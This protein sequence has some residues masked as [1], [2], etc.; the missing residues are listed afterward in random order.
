[1]ER[2]GDPRA[3]GQGRRQGRPEGDLRLPARDGADT[4]FSGQLAFDPKQNNFW[5]ST[6]GL[7]QIQNGDWVTVWPADRAAGQLKP[8]AS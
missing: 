7:K 1:M 8:P 4:T 3:G 6:P 2:L 5:P